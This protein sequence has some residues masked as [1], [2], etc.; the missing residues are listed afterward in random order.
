VEPTTLLQAC[1]DDARLLLIAAEERWGRPVLHCPEWDAAELVR[2]TGSVLQWMATIV[3]SGERVSRR[4]LGTGPENLEDLPAWYLATLDRTL[5]VLGSADPDSETWTFSSAGENRVRW[6]CRRVA[7]EVAIH[8]WDAERAGVVDGGPAPGPVE[9]DVAAEGIEEFVQEFLPGLLERGDGEGIA[10]TLHLHAVDG[11]TEWTIDFD[12]GGSAV[13]AHAKADTA[14][15]GTRS[16][17]LL[18][19]LNR[20]PLDSLEVFGNEN[21]LDR[22]GQLQF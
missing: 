1:D 14:I 3:D 6:W 10:G 4:S 8:R 12:D 15:R 19:L 18:W 9:G 17:I 22:W 16:D 13:V 5:D 2:H 20:G 7:V 21:L 11:P